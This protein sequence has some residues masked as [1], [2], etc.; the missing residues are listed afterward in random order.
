MKR[1]VTAMLLTAAVAMSALTGCSGDGAG[2]A[3]GGSAGGGD[4][5]G[6]EEITVTMMLTEAATQEQPETSPLTEAIKEK[7]N[8]NLEL[9]IVPGADYTTK[10]STTLA[11]N[12]MPDIVSGMTIDEVKQY[13]PSG[14]F[15]NLDDYKELAPDYYALVEAEDR[16]METNKLRVNGGLYQFQKLAYYTVTNGPL[17]GMRMDLLEEQDIPVPSTWEEYYDA[18]LKIKE[19]HP[20]MYGLST[21][22]GTSYLIGALAYPMGTGGFPLFN[23]TRGMY[24]EPK[25]DTYVYGPTSDGFVRVVEF[26]RQAYADGI[27]DPDYATMDKDTLFEKLSSGKLMSV[28]DNNSFMAR[29]YNPALQEID[30]NAYF[31]LVDPLADE[32]GN[33]RAYQYAKDWTDNVAVISVQ[34]KYPERIVEMMNWLYTD[35]GRMI[36]NYGKEGELYDLVDGEPVIKQEALD[37]VKDASDPSTALM[38]KFGGGLLGLAFYVDNGIEKQTSDPILVEQGGRIDQLA[39]EGIITPFP[40]YPSFTDEEQQ[41]V[42]EIEQKLSNVF[43][44]EIDGF[45]TGKKSMEEWPALVETL[46]SQGSQELESIFNAAYDRVKG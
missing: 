42:T 43:N 31:D 44:Q 34:T 26:L 45:I 20:D 11:S 5:G 15:L 17:L 29:T 4:A 21:R 33:V 36:S 28:Y 22:N 38:G 13:A 1:K 3:G 35:E 7:F 40:N 18:M 39:Q 32:D 9:M 27:L 2:N 14:M 16:K 23:S 24:L 25:T 6:R 46:Q 10:K 37:G 30:E 8:I 19:K 12:S 41:K